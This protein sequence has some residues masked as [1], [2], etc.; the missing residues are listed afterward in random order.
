MADNIVNLRLAR[1]RKK[2]ADKDKVAEQNRVH[3]GRTKDEKT[4]TERLNRKAISDLDQKKL[5]D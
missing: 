2:R 3:F 5:E 4:L 1:K